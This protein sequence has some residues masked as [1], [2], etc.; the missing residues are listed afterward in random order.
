MN[1]VLP[2]HDVDASLP[3]ISSAIRLQAAL[4]P[5]RI[6]IACSG[7]PPFSFGELAAA[8]ERIGQ[9]FHAAGIGAGSR[10][11]ILLPNGPEA[12]VMGVAAAAHSICYPLDPALSAAE[13][14]S[15]IDRVHLD[16]IVL[17]DWMKLPSCPIGRQL[18][19]LHASQAIGSLADVC[20]TSIDGSIELDDVRLPTAQSVAIVQTSSGS[21]GLPK[22]VLVTHANVLDVA[23]KLQAWFGISG[24]DRSACILPVPSGIGFKVTLLAPL[25]IGSGVVIAARQR[26]DEV[27]EWAI[28]HDPTW[29]F[30]APAYLNAV[31]DALR[32]SGG[33]LPKHSLR[34]V[35]TG[36]THVPE[37]L[38]VDLEAALGIAV[39]EQYG[40]RESGPITANPAPPATRKPGTVGPVSE[41]IA[42]FDDSGAML[43]PGSAG[44]LAVRGQGISPG[45]IE[46]L[47]LGADRVPDGRSPDHWLPTG[48]IGVVDE[49]GFLTIVGR[50]KQIIN[51]GG[52]KIA[53]SEVESALQQHPLVRDAAVFGVPHPRLGEGVSAAVV[54]Q[55]GAGVTSADLQDF[56]F[57]RLAPHKIPQSLHFVAALPRNAGGKIQLSQLVEQVSCEEHR[58]APA[59]GNL[60]ILIIEIWR[61]LL[62]RN[63]IGVDDNFFELGGDS[64]LATSMLLE[65]EELAKRQVP[66]S[67]L[68]AV[69]TIRQLVSVILRDMPPPDG[70]VTPVKTGSG[71]PLFFCHGDRRDR[72]IYALR[73]MGMIEHD[74]PIFLLNHHREFRSA[75]DLSLEDIARLYVPHVVA[76]Q[77]NGPV[78]LGG[79]CV[80]GLIALEVAHQ[81]KSAGRDIEFVALIDSPSLNGRAS[82]QAW[83]A[84]LDTTSRVLPR[85]SRARIASNGMWAAWVLVRSRPVVW[86]A[87]TKLARLTAV[88][89]SAGRG[90]RPPRWDEYRRLSNYIP[91]RSATPLHCFVCAENAERI[92]F[93]PSNW[94]GLTPAVYATIIPGDH[95]SCVTRFA[96]VLASQLQNIM[97][98]RNEQNDR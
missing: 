22:H 33:S 24:N 81:L 95:H 69:W 57:G 8:I 6:A 49:D 7:L 63:D 64:L 28:D 21:T 91:P 50:A 51:R 36:G 15:E 35:L 4:Y 54:A 82:M 74:F 34:F 89:L 72:G 32:V 42:A 26:A 87:L 44:T 62:E 98:I 14:E 39:V 27:A 86:G 23:G 93:K 67:A 76:A 71:A 11:G 75:E 45:Y 29:F 48:D 37:R 47:P 97:P 53:P 68:R 55:P 61:R 79:Y 41:N 96:N 38:R 70:P 31:L 46:A 84:L 85:K 66:P 58:P 19:I 20:L 3:T 25:L 60:E 77:P 40:S 30:G 12:A 9:Q 65:V 43:P 52:E 83:K 94:R 17:P 13:L 16:A 78:R 92:D 56:L 73:L 80:G 88:K 90:A 10:V 5:D 18:E 59:S 2:P 1:R